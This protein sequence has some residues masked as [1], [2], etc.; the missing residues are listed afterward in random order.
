MGGRLRALLCVVLLCALTACGLP[1]GVDGDLTDDWAV[2]PAPGAFRPRAGVC[3]D[4]LDDTAPQASYAPFD[5]ADR[6]LAET[7]FVGDLTGSPS[8][9]DA[10]V[11]AYARCSAGATAFV[12]APWRTGRLTV[13]QVLPGPDAWTG[14]ARWFRCDIGELDFSTGHPVSRTG[15]LRGALAA[16]GPVRLRCFDPRVSGEQVHGMARVPCDR[17][18]HA[19]FAGL[20]QAPRSGPRIR[21][22]DPRLQRGCRRT[23]ARFAGVPDDGDLQYRVGWLAFTPDAEWSLGERAVQCFLWLDGEPLTGSFAGAGTARL[24]VHYA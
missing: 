9:G 20:W 5:C 23:I 7:F 3:F 24:P 18:H 10:A 2:P 12:G 15:T 6:H 17:P 22:D 14:G 1:G 16:A 13:Q 4:D 8:D 11:Q 19:E 21:D